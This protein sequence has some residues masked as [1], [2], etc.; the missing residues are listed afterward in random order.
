MVA[1][2]CICLQN[3]K[4]TQVRHFKRC[5][6]NVNLDAI[7]SSHFFLANYSMH[8][9]ICIYLSYIFCVSFCLTVHYHVVISDKEEIKRIYVTMAFFVISLALNSIIDIPCHRQD[10]NNRLICLL[11]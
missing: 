2:L 5:T 4:R 3:C 7:S 11:I 6:P 1:P 9:V 10:K 8:F